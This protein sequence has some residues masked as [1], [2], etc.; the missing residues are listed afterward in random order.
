MKNKQR[1]QK[2]DKKLHWHEKKQENLIKDTRRWIEKL[3]GSADV[4]EQSAYY[5]T[6]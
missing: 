4:D 2:Y 5:E 3:T 6:I 1:I